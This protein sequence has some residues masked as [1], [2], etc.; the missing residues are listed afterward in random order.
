MQVTITRSKPNFSTDKIKTYV[1]LWDWN[2]VNTDGNPMYF[3]GEESYDSIDGMLK[4]L[5]GT[6]E[7]QLK[8]GVS[9]EIA[10]LGKAK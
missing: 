4:D 8:P 3:T 5:K 10:I 7:D 2:V 1:E 6:L 9:I